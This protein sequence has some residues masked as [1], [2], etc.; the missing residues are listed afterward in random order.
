MG[1][2]KTVTK[3][4]NLF[5]LHVFVTVFILILAYYFFKKINLKWIMYKVKD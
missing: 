3:S 1:D 5:K 2:I 4:W